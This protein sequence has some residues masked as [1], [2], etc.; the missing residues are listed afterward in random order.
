MK[1]TIIILMC[2]LFITYIYSC[3][4]D[5]SNAEPAAIP[6]FF[7]VLDSITG[8][9]LLENR[10]YTSEN[11]SIYED[12]YGKIINYQTN[13]IKYNGVTCGI[14]PVNNSSTFIIDYKNNNIDTL[15]FHF[16]YP[17]EGVC[18][19]IRPFDLYNNHKL[20]CIRC[21]QEMIYVFKK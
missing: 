11:V 8:E 20:I 4:D 14:L 5:C 3:K 18:G 12:R 2:L 13:F 10:T 9:N 15:V 7:T 19:V 17:S 16:H 6:F 1:K 21:E